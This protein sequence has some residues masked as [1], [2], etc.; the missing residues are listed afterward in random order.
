ME[1]RN[2]DRQPRGALLYL[3]ALTQVLGFEAGADKALAAGACGGL[4]GA[5]EAAGAL[6]V[7]RPVGFVGAAEAGALG[8]AALRRGNPERSLL[9]I[10]KAVVCKS[11]QNG[12]PNV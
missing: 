1:A 6:A 9:A 7:A 12:T 3:D 4:L 2:G 11:T 10:L 8:G 5:L